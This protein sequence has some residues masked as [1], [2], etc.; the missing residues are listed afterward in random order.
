METRG[1]TPRVWT[2]ASDLAELVALPGPF[3]TVLIA[4]EAGVEQASSRNETRWRSRRSDLA[5]GGAPEEVLS[6]VDPLVPDAHL[7][8]EAMFV[9]ATS[10]GVHHVSHWPASPAHELARWASLPSLV[11]LLDLRQSLPP[12]VVV[13]ADRT[14]ADLTAVGHDQPDRT[15]SVD[16]ETHHARKVQ[17]G[18]W[19]Q[20]RYQERAENVWEHNAKEVADAVVR[21]TDQV[22]A[23]LVVLTGDV[24]AVEVLREVLPD[25]VAPL[26]QVLDGSRAADGAPGVDAEQLEATLA[27]VS[28]GE[29]AALVEKL[30]EEQGQGDRSAT[31]ADAVAA[32]LA[33]AQVE[34]LL[35]HDRPDDERQ[36]WF[37]DDATLVATSPETLRQLGVDAPRSGRL[38]DVFVRGALGTGAG[39]HVVAEASRL[40]EGVAALLRWT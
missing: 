12:H 36:A 9:V 32:T 31:G 10:D 38:V 30:G 14:G 26:V 15:G 1:D 11:P 23:R 7:R 29:S 40:D 35:V 21:L 27:A 2:D 16:G 13:V 17:A 39:V 22:G 3:L 28:A 37:G 24:R 6:L 4:T 20:R 18:G 19:S 8:G 33:R 25:E 34:V 5:G